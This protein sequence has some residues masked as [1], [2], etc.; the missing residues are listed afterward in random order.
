MCFLTAEK[1]WRQDW[2]GHC[3]GE[4]WCCACISTLARWQSKRW[5]HTRSTSMRPR[6]TALTLNTLYV[7]YSAPFQQVR[8][9][10][11][12]YVFTVEWTGTCKLY[13]IHRNHSSVCVGRRT[14]QHID[15]H[16]RRRTCIQ[17]QTNT[18]RTAGSAGSTRGIGVGF[19]YMLR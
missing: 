17:T 13:S 14:R 10:R 8:T 2:Q 19:T 12:N 18:H 6:N 15:S 7:F 1:S 11:N 5:W 3:D 9:K 4:K 16:P